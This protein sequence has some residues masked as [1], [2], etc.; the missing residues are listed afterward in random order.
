MLKRSVRRH[1][2][3]I[4]TKYYKEKELETYV[5]CANCGLNFAVYGIFANCPDCNNLN[6]LTVFEKSIEAA[7]K[8]LKLIE[9]IDDNELI[10]V[11]LKDALSGG[12]SAFDALGKFLRSRYTYIFPEKPKNLFQN[13][14]S[15]DYCLRGN[16]ETS[17]TDILGEEEH[18]FIVKMFQVRHI[19]E[20]NLGV[21]DEDFIRKLP[22]YR[23]HKGRKYV[24]D[25]NETSEFL[26][27]LLKTGQAL[28]V[29]IR[30]TREEP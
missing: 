15:L 2:P 20:H 12:V 23:S 8:M 29:S 3:F 21:I 7:K 24:L 28:I 10:G 9:S 17:L 4:S 1:K 13:L 27:I 18:G 30:E 11:L 22:A 5:V 19:Y 25:A 14:T 26:D 16:L 6:A